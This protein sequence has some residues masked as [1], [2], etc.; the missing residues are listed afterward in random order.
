MDDN[1]LIYTI[2]N[3]NRNIDNIIFNETDV[4]L[5]I[6]IDYKDYRINVEYYF[7]VESAYYSIFKEKKLIESSYEPDSLDGV[8]ININHFIKS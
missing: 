6:K 4:S 7:D 2:I 8:L 1:L 5:F 3:F